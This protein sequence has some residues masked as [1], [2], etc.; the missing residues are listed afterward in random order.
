VIKPVIEEKK[1]VE[2]KPNTEKASVAETIKEEK[3]PI[4][5]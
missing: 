4:E 5:I 1:A 3:K 2:T